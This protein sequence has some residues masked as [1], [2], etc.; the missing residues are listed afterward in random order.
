MGC[1]EQ[2]DVVET[3]GKD[4]Y[5]DTMNTKVR[6]KRQEVEVANHFLIVAKPKSQRH[7]SGIP[8]LV[9]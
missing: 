2:L 9:K 3:F 4:L 8:S 6:G 7:D 5:T 1:E